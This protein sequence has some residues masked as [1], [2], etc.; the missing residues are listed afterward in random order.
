MKTVLILT[1]RLGR[2]GRDDRGGRIGHRHVQGIAADG[3]LR[4]RPRQCRSRQHLLCASVEEHARRRRAASPGLPQGRLLGRHGGALPT[5]IRAAFPGALSAILVTLRPGQSA[6]ATARF[7]PDVPGTGEQTIGACE[8]T[9]YRLRVTARGGGTTHGEGA[10]ADRRSAS[11]AG[12]SSRRTA[13][14]ACAC[15]SCRRRGGRR[16]PA[17]ASA[18]PAAASAGSRSPARRPAPGP[19]PCRRAARPA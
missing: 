6:R 11:T 13:A 3:Q 12:C 9:A 1:R 4:R 15:V 19:P 18:R 10:A 16:A 8:P 2:A 14:S 17:A 7:S 5:K